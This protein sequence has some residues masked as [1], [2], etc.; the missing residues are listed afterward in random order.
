MSFLPAPVVERPRSGTGSVE[1]ILTTRRRVNITVFFLIYRHDELN[2]TVRKKN[3]NIK[4]YFARTLLKLNHGHLTR[5]S[6]LLPIIWLPGEV[7]VHF[8]EILLSV[9]STVI[10]LLYDDV[11]G[12]DSSAMII[13]TIP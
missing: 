9:A 6:D 8:E 7:Q 13:I 4:Y 11:T 5:C 2:N 1:N 12:G 3:L 10:L